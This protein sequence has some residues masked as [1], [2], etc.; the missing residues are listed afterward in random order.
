LQDGLE[1]HSRIITN[2][3]DMLVEYPHPEEILWVK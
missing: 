2:T 1:K 3:K